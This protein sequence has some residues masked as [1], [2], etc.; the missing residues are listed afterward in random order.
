MLQSQSHRESSCDSSTRGLTPLCPVT[1]CD[2]LF[3]CLCLSDFKSNFRAAP[4]R[5]VDVYNVMCHA[6]GIAPL[7]NNGSWS[8]VMCMLK[9]PASAA[10]RHLPG[11]LALALTLLLLLQ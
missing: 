10:P 2:N 11:G 5:S 7:P 3:V 6:A 1:D 8:R 4:I 9:S